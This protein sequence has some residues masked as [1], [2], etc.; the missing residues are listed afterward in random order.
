MNQP[1]R[2][3]ISRIAR[4]KVS[5]Q[6]AWLSDNDGGRGSGRLVIRINRTGSCRFYAR[7]SKPDGRRVMVPLGP[8]SKNRTKGYLT[9]DE[10]RAAARDHC[11][12]AVDVERVRPTDHRP[13]GTSPDPAA[14]EPPPNSP[15]SR[16]VE[17]LGSTPAASGTLADLCRTYINVL[18]AAGKL[19]VLDCESYF[20]RHIEPSEYASVPAGDLTPE[21]AT[22]LIRKIRE[23]GKRCTAKHVRSFL[24]AAY[25]KACNAKLDT[26]APAALI[27][28][29]IISN[30]ISK[31]PAPRNNGVQRKRNL[32]VAANRGEVQVAQQ[33]FERTLPRDDIEPDVK[34]VLR[35]TKWL[36][37]WN[38]KQRAEVAQELQGLVVEE[39]NSIALLAAVARLARPSDKRKSEAALL[40]V[41]Q[42]AG[43]KPPAEVRLLLADLYSDLKDFKRAAKFYQS[44]LPSEGAGELHAR[45]LHSLLRS[46][47]RRKAK[48][49][50]ERLPDGWVNNDDL[51]SLATEIAHDAGDWPLLTRLADAQFA[52]KPDDIGS[53]LF[54]Y[55]MGSRELPAAEL[56]EFIGRAPLGLTGSI[57]Q[58]SQLAFLELRLGL[59]GK[60]VQ[61]LYQ[62]RRL[63][64]VKI[65]SASALMMAYLAYNEPIAELP[66]LTGL[67]KYLHPA[68]ESLL[69][70]EMRVVRVDLL[71]GGQ[72]CE[73]LMRV[74]T[75][76]VDTDADTILLYDPKGKR[77]EPREH[78]L[79][80]LPQAKRDVLWFLQHSQLLGSEFLFAGR[81]Q[82]HSLHPNTVS[83]AVVN[84]SDALQRNKAIASR[85]EYRDLRRTVETRM[86][87]L[88]VAPHIR[89]HIQS[90]DLS[91]VQI[92]HYDMWEYLPQKHDALAKWARFLSSLLAPPQQGPAEQPGIE[93]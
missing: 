25:T 62:M 28:F 41:R 88:G 40:R 38:A 13:R 53:W 76:E 87:Q 67:W 26:E 49:V 21:Q 84:I 92:K 77:D 73:Q 61:R 34:E 12:G 50:L 51:R 33:I 65:E 2:L 70:I 71:L 64:A 56:K 22:N 81:H 93:T 45:L 91:G 23:A 44:V 32:S 69:T 8:Y 29:G 16:P 6:N 30:P 80:M 52:R 48:E 82:A 58:V 35:A 46:G 31:V 17:P 9:L 14:Q 66:E 18:K 15:P 42:L 75:N 90:H 5:G 20:R 47:D 39:S 78:L 24:H 1:Q 86:A 79:P 55:M 72:R 68:D 4:A 7:Y 54:K 57:Q 43:K 74:K 60:A 83:K 19:S 37:M 10:G 3:T 36:A 27:A 63:N 59:Q 85:F 11:S 89:A